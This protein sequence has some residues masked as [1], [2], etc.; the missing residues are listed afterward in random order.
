MSS[1]LGKL[2]QLQ[3]GTPP[4][5]GPGWLGG[6]SSMCVRTDSDSSRFSEVRMDPMVR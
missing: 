3:G 4:S 2:L 1:S 6:V 5:E